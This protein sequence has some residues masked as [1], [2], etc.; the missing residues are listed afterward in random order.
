MIEAGRNSMTST[1]LR[2]AVVVCC[3]AYATVL[4]TFAGAPLT[5]MPR[6]GVPGGS[7][8]IDPDL[9]IAY[10]LIGAGAATGL[11]GGSRRVG[12]LAALVGVAWLGSS[13]AGA[14]HGPQGIGVLGAA[15]QPLLVVLLLALIVALG[16][17][18]PRGRVT[19]GLLAAALSLAALLSVLR[20]V[21]YDPFYDPDCTGCGHVVPLLDLTPVVRLWF[22]RAAAAL[23][24]VA[25][26]S[27]AVYGFASLRSSGWVPGSRSL[28]V[29]GGVLAGVGLAGRA[30]LSV[31]G[32]A[33]LQRLGATGEVID[34]ALALAPSVGG[35]LLWIGLVWS[36][37][38][39]LRLRVRMHRL[40]DDIASAAAPHALESRLAEALQDGSVTVGYWLAEERRYIGAD[41]G[42]LEAP[43]PGSGLSFTA[44]ERDG[45]PVAAV[46]HRA[47]LDAGAVT[48]EV[49]T[50]MLVALDNER[51]QAVSLANLRSLRASRARI[52]TVEE[53][54]RRRVERDLHDG[55]Q[56]RMLAIVF[57]L[58]LA[59]L[60]AARSGDR[61]RAERLA[62]AEGLA[63]TA[64]EELRRLAHGI[65]PA[66]LS[67]AGLAPALASLADEAPIPMTVSMQ[68]A[69]RLS[70]SVEAAVYQLVV[71]A[72]SDALRLGAGELSIAVVPGAVEVAVEID[73][74]GDRAAGWPV[75]L[76][77]RVAA[78]GGALEVDPGVGGSG[79]RIRAA[80]PCA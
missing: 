57:D 74:D 50:S 24:V 52:V 53:E 17:R 35:I 71:D 42:P 25:G 44:I 62:R 30:A 10:A 31:G 54:E 70:V 60:N 39:V 22:A 6:T 51:L 47:G 75:R 13:P 28:A 49:T 40:A 37:V 65:H 1:A 33:G 45:T 41:G 26:V 32:S 61:G 66:V 48:A 43:G 2:L 46:R 68:P 11:G 38:H 77:D 8:L 78:A 64:V 67:Q 27:A 34:S 58:R 12:L 59:G 29:A 20:L 79:R 80:L 16:P 15:V 18:G 56:Q 73:H 55:V 4:V 72:L 23:A 19:V 5:G 69:T 3:A 36:I 21:A 76:A 7:S 14:G 9:I 63:L